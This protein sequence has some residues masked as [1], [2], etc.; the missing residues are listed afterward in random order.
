MNSMHLDYKAATKILVDTN[1]LIK[2]QVVLTS[3]NIELMSN[4]ILRPDCY[5]I[6][7][8][9]EIKSLPDLTERELRE[10]HNLSKIYKSDGFNKTI[11]EG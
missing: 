1:K 3:N 7:N 6:I 5:F 2:H 9:N 4:K 10:G 8:N 11:N